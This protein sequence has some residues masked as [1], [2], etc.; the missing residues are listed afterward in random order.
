MATEKWIAGSGQGLTWGA[1]FGSVVDTLASG[2]AIA[3]SIAITNGT[4]LDIFADISMSLSSAAFASP[5]YMAFYLYPLNQDG[6]SYGDGNFTS[7][8]TLTPPSNYFINTI[9]IS[10]TAGPQ[11]GSLVRAVLPPGTF[12]FV[13][14][15]NGGVTLGSGN[16]IQYRTYNRSIA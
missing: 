12:K 14:Q 2:S 6:T 15:N 9:G 10:T 7:A 11:T 3:S 5:L 4:A 1:A 8:S 16:T 13:I